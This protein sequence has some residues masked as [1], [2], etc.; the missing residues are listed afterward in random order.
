MDKT[1]KW[2]VQNYILAYISVQ[3]CVYIIAFPSPQSG[4][5]CDLLSL[6]NIIP[7]REIGIHTAISSGCRVFHCMATP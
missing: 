5:S 3:M 7:C 1:Q 2:L 4:M 6:L